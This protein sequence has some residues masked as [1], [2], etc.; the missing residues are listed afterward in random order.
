M[1]ADPELIPEVIAPPRLVIQPLSW[2]MLGL[3]TLLGLIG[4]LVLQVSWGLNI[5]IWVSL[6]LLSVSWFLRQYKLPNRVWWFWLM[7]LVFAWFFVL[8]DSSLLRFWNGLAMFLAL[9]LA[10]AFSRSGTG[11]LG[12]VALFWAW[13]ETL[14][15]GLFGWL[16]FIRQA[17]WSQITMQTNPKQWM[18]FIRGGLLLLPLLLIFASLLGSADAVFASLVKQIFTWNVDAGFWWWLLRFFFMITLV[19]G[20]LRFLLLGQTILPPGQPV[21]LGRIELMIVLGGLNALFL[22]FMVIQFG[23]FFGGQTQVT[24]LTGLTYA[25]YARRGFNELVQVV[26]LAFPVLIISL[27]VAQSDPRT[28]RTV[29]LLSAFTLLLLAM[30]LYSAWQRLGLYREAYGLT[31]TRFYTTV[32]LI[33]LAVM[34]VYY[35]VTAL[36]ERYSSFVLGTVISAFLTLMIL[37]VLNP[38]ALIVQSNLARAGTDFD[39]NYAIGLGAD[40]VPSLITAKTRFSLTEQ[41]YLQLELKKRWGVLNTDWRSWNLAVVQA[42][43]ASQTP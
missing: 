31:E 16:G 7:T 37:N 27:Q 42:Y 30:M 39:L 24:Q 18:P 36:R 19:L 17:P 43:E 13:F 6:F 20:L 26:V 15:N 4:S 21:Q 5:A 11:A 8:R 23:Y 25:D 14:S 41:R 22:V 29:R 35:A 32:G 9:G 28:S 38:H 33:W 2:V 10:T 34:L 40:A 12:F 3:A 1:N